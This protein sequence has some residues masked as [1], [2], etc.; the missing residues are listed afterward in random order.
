MFRAAGVALLALAFL[1][2]ASS[3]LAD[4]AP[5]YDYRIVARYAMDPAMFVQ[6]LLYEGEGDGDGARLYISSGLYHVSR[7]RLIDFS[8]GAILAEHRLAPQYFA[9]GIVRVGDQIIQL[10]WREQTAFRYDAETLAPLG[11]FQYRGE[12]WGLTSLAGELVMSNGSAELAV[13]D[14]HSFEVLRTIAVTDGG[15]PVQGLNALQ[16]IDGRVYAN[17]FPTTRIA[18][19]EPNT[20]T[21]SGWLDL[22]AV[23]DAVAREWRLPIDVL[24]GIAYDAAANRVFVGGKLWPWLFEIE[25]DFFITSS[26]D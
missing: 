1:T 16:A 5:V 17:I 25:S 9:E 24:N 18:R 4:E 15:R 23:R 21:V 12:G 8:S 19:I 22:S 14:P 6:G 20:G 3:A 26:S 7:L 10:T 11:T 13:R 2:G